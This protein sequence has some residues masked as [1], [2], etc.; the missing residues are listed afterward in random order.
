MRRRIITESLKLSGKG[1]IVYNATDPGRAH[2][3]EYGHVI[4][5]KKGQYGRAPAHPHIKPA[6][7]QSVELFIETLESELN[8]TL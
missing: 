2:L 6:E 7:E 1:A 8:K 4:K 3:L 5:N